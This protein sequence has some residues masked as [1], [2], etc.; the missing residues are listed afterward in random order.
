VDSVTS[1]C[2]L[3]ALP[4]WR[5]SMLTMCARRH[6]ARCNCSLV[7]R[8]RRACLW[9]AQRACA[10]PLPEGGAKA[11]SSAC[12]QCD[13]TLCLT[14]SAASAFVD[15]DHVLSSPLSVP[16]YLWK[17]AFIGL[18]TETAHLKTSLKFWGLLRKRVT[19]QQGLPGVF[20]VNFPLED[21]KFGQ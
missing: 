20:C 2:V 11:R 21:S 14:S 7:A 15:A 6:L 9:C 3:P 4:R 10:M 12:G 16:Y 18:V 17:L 5:L 1:P 13:V 19:N 8:V